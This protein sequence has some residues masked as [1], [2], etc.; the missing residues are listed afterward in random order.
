MP[1]ATPANDSITERVADVGGVKLQYLTAGHGPGI[2]LLHGYAETSRM[3]KPLMPMLAS[4]FTSSLRTCLG[5]AAPTC[6]AT[7]SI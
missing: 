4:N 2:A 6:P 3:W 7:A 1:G 5:S